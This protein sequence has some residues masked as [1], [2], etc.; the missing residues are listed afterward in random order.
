MKSVD[1]HCDV[2]YKMLINNGADFSA[3]HSDILDVT[4]N[5]LRQAKTVVQAFAVY[6]PQSRQDWLAAVLESISYF[7]SEVVSTF[8]MRA[9][10]NKK[11]LNKVL[12]AGEIGALLT[13]EGTDGLYGKPALLDTL[14][15]LGI[16]MIG[17]TWN[18]ANWAADGALEPRNGGL[19]LKGREFVQRCEQTG[20]LLDVSHL[21]ERSFWELLEHTERPFV[22]SHSNCAALCSHPRNLNDA[23][24]NAVIAREG[25]IGITYVPQFLA[26]ERKATLYDIV[27]HI[28]HICMLGGEQTI[29]LGSDFDGIEQ[30]VPDLE[31]PGKLYNLVNEL[32]KYYT[33]HQVKHFL[34]Y[35]ALLFLES[36][37]PKE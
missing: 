29:V 36:H 9:V 6:I 35:N 27:C 34:S 10:T 22:A 11:E 2:L 1:L 16:R 13:L 8:G 23:Q 4:Y 21:S 5:R 19:T 31:H 12:A 3:N 17:L 15:R 7:N 32:L 25:R 30:H 28:E 14:Y 33:E 24:I 18:F 20:I 26:A 37:L